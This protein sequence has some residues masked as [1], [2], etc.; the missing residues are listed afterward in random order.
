MCPSSGAT[1]LATDRHPQP[2]MTPNQSA[3]E[4]EMRGIAKA[5]GGV[6]AL[7]GVDLVVARRSVH[8]IV[9][10]NGAGKSTLMKVLS[11]AQAPDAG[12]VWVDGHAVVIDSPHAATISGI[13]T[14]YQEPAFYPE[15]T[16]L[17]NFHSGSELVG[18]F[19]INWSK[20][21]A[22]A[23]AALRT[24]GLPHRLADQPMHRLPIGIQ[25]LVLIAR[26]VSRRP[27]ILILDEPTSML[28]QAETQRLFRL[29]REM[30]AAG[31][32]ILYVSHRIEEVFEIT[33]RITVLRDGAVA[34]VVAT[35]TATEEQLVE[36]MSGRKIQRDLYQPP[37][38]VGVPLI[39]VRGLTRPAMYRDVSFDVRHG[40]I[41]GVYGL[42]GAGRSEVA[43]ALFGAQ[44][45]ESG[46]IRFDG[47]LLRPASPRAAI[48]AGIAYLPEDRRSQGL[49][50][51]RS[52][53]HNLTIAVI[54]ALVG[55]FGRIMADRER[56]MSR[57]VVASLRVRTPH[58]NV[59]VG[60]LSGGSQQKVLFGRWLLAKPRLLML[61][62][63]TRGIDV[64]T[65][66][67]IHRLI[68][69]LA[70]EG[71]NAV[72]LISS[73]L[74]EVLAISDRVMVMR[75]GTVRAIL[76]REEASEQKVLRLALGL[77]EAGGL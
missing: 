27:R 21:R 11:G 8:A 3:N 5:F 9:G 35:A 10:E 18:R 55:R 6:Q 38:T 77:G 44:P 41:L 60:T 61:D 34:G 19:G 48:E 47:R 58:E 63:P 14:V 20:E 74:A 23:V 66:T 2:P 13:Q 16:V 1:R 39:E 4:L 73:E 75:E 62:E 28:S 22:A 15:L 68:V 69:D 65:K 25:Q 30:Q 33:D 57:D 71:K 40:E 46:Q 7:V 32:A 64:G 72:L 36:L 54:R 49:F 76:S 45:A 43:L 37:K 31:T 56:R 70:R 59:P 51:I 53:A 50:L 24:V 42:V 12:E 29:V 52:V 17:E 67:E 26:A